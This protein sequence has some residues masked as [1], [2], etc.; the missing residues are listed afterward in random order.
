MKIAAIIG[1]G[2]LGLY[3]RWKSAQPVQLPPSAAAATT[4]APPANSNTAHGAVLYHGLTP[5]TLIEGGAATAQISA[6]ARVL[7]NPLRAVTTSIPGRA[8]SLATDVIDPGQVFRNT[9]HGTAGA[10]I[11][12][13]ANPGGTALDKVVSWL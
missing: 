13:I 1:A 5:G 4:P 9:G 7:G 6:R 10:V 3:L 12:A 2:A 11:S 8:G